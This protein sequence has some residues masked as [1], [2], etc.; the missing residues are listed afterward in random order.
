MSIVLGILSVLCGY[1]SFGAGNPPVIPVVGIAF[2][3]AGLVRENRGLK[4]KGVL[5]LC[6]LA[7]VLSVVG[8][9][10]VFARR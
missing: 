1:L 8:T 4:R 9:V 5:V 6:V 3:A 2:A 7:L 10:L